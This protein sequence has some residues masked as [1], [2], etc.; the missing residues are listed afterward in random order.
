MNFV[1]ISDTEIINLDYVATIRKGYS[2]LYDSF[3]I[4]VNTIGEDQV[5][6]QFETKQEMEEKWQSLFLSLKQRGKENE[7]LREN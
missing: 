7:N 2:D 3:V 6:L 1:K 4:Y 5:V